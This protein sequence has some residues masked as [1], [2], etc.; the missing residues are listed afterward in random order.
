MPLGISCHTDT[1]CCSYLPDLVVHYLSLLLAISHKTSLNYG[2]KSELTV[3]S[4][5]P[6][7]H[8]FSRVIVQCSC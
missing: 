5:A 2:T 6:T 7:F 1:S 8:N 4:R 3:L